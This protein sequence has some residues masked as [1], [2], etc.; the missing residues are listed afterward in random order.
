M[1][2][3][4]VKNIAIPEGNV[5]KITQ[6]NNVLWQKEEAEKIINLID[7][8][9]YE[10]SKRLSTSSGSVKD[11]SGMFITG[12]I[13]AGEVGDVYRT[14]GIKFIDANKM[15]GIWFYKEDSTFWTYIDLPS[16]GSYN[17]KFGTAVLDSN[18]NLTITV[19]NTTSAAKKWRLCAYGSGANLLLTKN[20]EIK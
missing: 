10:N 20:Q 13:E 2:F 12:L 18:G 11:Q 19:T 3:S 1:I 17:V 5:V 15:G 16:A 9:G 6:G 14:S 8:V 7:T 4:N